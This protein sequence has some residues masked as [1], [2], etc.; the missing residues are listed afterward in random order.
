MMRDFV[1]S[2]NF[3][4]AFNNHSYSNLMLRPWGYTAGT[5]AEEELYDELSEQ[6]CWHNRYHYGNGNEVN[7]VRLI[8]FE[9]TQ[10]HYPKSFQ[11]FI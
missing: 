7:D 5:H 11:W 6:M 9:A 10:Y 4:N 8:W 2:H 3:A 1:Q